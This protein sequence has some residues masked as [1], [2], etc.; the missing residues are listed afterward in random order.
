MLH[1]FKVLITLEYIIKCNL[2]HKWIYIPFIISVSKGM[3]KNKKVQ[4]DCFRLFRLFTL[5]TFIVAPYSN[6]T[7]HVQL[8][9]IN[10]NN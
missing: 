6:Y 3:Q 7:V 2:I 8:L 10:T 9:N 1:Y 4:S 5:Y